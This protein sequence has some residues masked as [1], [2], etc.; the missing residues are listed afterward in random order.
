[1]LGAPTMTAP[2]MPPPRPHSRPRTRL[3][4]TADALGSPA[5]WGRLGMLAVIVVSCAVLV[6]ALLAPVA[7]LADS[8]LATAAAGVDFGP[9]PGFTETAERSTV[10]DRDGNVIA[11]L[12]EENRT[13]VDLDEVPEHVVAAVV[14][15]EDDRFREHEGVNWRAVARAAVGNL[16]AGEITSGASTITQQLVKKTVVGVGE[17]QTF[18]RKIREA[19][20]A[21]E[22]ERQLTKD[23]ILERY[24]NEIYLGNRVYGIGTAAE[25]YWG[26]DVGEL[27]LSDGALL[28]GMI[29]SPAANDPVRH[30][31]AARQRRDIVLAQMVAVGALHADEAARTMRQPLALDVR[32]LPP[33]QNPF[34]VT[35]VR[36]L[37]LQ[38]P[39]LGATA[40]ERERTL[41]RGGLT[42]RT[43]IDPQLQALADAAI[44]ELLTDVE[45]PQATLPVVDP[46]TGD[47]LAVG[48]GP[49]TFGKGPGKTQVNPALPGVG[50]IG[51]QSGSTFKA[52]GIVAALEAGVSPTYTMDT[53][54]PY[55]AEN[56]PTAGGPYTV[57]NYSDG[58]GGIMDMAAAM[59]M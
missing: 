1:M 31:Q 16:G 48:F 36:T 23:A 38:D 52:F 46:R 30:P 53:P 11:V 19:V 45:G 9:L 58:G 49:R 43:T 2:T 41:L 20:Y 28:A 3:Q 35:Y 42:V 37:L 27:T 14:A 51:R 24:L 17:E 8:T 54:S 4:A 59:S 39:A 56:C 18:A 26:K 47:I 29:R 34:W 25:Y 55:V 15:T 7:S 32:P 21:I 57:G 13:L 5:T 10:L 22:L 40:D 44:A 50:S 6:A 33:P 12:R